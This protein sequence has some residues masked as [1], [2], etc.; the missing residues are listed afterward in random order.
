MLKF[1]VLVTNEQIF[2]RDQVHDMLLQNEYLASQIDINENKFDD[3]I[4]EKEVR[5]ITEL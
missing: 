5:I 2:V 1:V 3:P 4:Q